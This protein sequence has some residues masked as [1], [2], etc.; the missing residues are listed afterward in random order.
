[1]KNLKNKWL[2]MDW[3]RRLFLAVGIV[4]IYGAIDSADIFIGIA[5]AYFIAKSWL[6]WGCTDRSCSIKH[7]NLKSND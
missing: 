7:S 5:G 6:N 3:V 1:M 4:F 2:E